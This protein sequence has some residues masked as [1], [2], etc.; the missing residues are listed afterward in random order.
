MNSKGL[1][2][3]AFSFSLLAILGAT[4]AARAQESPQAPPA[5]E[6]AGAAGDSAGSS[7]APSGGLNL[8][9]KLDDLVKQD[10]LVPGLS[11]PVSTVERQT[12]TIG[13]SPTA[14]FVIT[15]E[16]IKRSGVRSIPE[17]LRMAPGIDVARVNSQTWA[18]SARGFNNTFANKLLVQI[19]G[20]VVYN[21]TFG[22]VYWNQQ[23]V[24][25][26]DVE[27]IE[28]IRGP[29]TTM[30]G[31]NAMNGVINVIT[32]KSSDTQGALIQSGGG[33]QE[34]DFNTVRYG[35]KVGEDLT[36]RAYGQ[37]FNRNRGWSDDGIDDTWL[38]QQ[39]GFRL[40]YTPTK[41][42]T[43]TLQGDL[44]DGSGGARY[45]LASPAPPFGGEINPVNQFPAGN[46]LLRYG[47]VIDEDTSWQVQTYYDHYQQLTPQILDETRD[48]WDIDLQY[49][50]RPAPNHQFI[51]GCNYRRSQD[52]FKNS[53]AVG[54]EPTRY[55]T[56]WSGVFAQDTMT[57]E[58]DRWYFTIGTRLEQNTFGGFQVEPTARLLFL[59]SDRQ[60]AWM[61]VSRAIRNPTRSDV[62]VN[63]KQHAGPPNVPVFLNILGNP[64]IQPENM[65]AYELG[66]RAAPTDDFTW[67]IAGYINDYH[68]IMGLGTIGGPVVVPP[69]YVFFPST[70]ENNARA[71]SYGCEVTGT[72]QLNPDWRLFASYS[73]FEVQS[74]GT[75]DSTAG[76]IEGSSPSNQVYLRSSWDLSEDVQ[77]DLI[78][79]YVDALTALDVPKYIEMDAR[80]GWQATKR[81]EF[82]FVG[83]NLLNN[84]HLE[85]SDIATGRI[86]TQ[87]RRGWYAMV[88][89]AY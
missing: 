28:V 72:Y 40:D 13:R 38:A 82:S 53:F 70:L 50:F 77:F 22:G 33:D 15:P 27:R 85:F 1:S 10:V 69:G 61:A 80:I 41:E 25:L 59:P 3:L 21:G 88:S 43:F 49:Q 48:T 32:K 47:R 19:D 26:P 36:W 87:V 5:G 35:G 57:L 9:M 29:G 86:P 44:F 31:S 8:D 14:V 7:G 39:G 62:N 56:E 71:L 24:V 73:L 74:Q 79:R 63:F 30:W 52:A 89:W 45:N 4:V 46:L 16:M 68:K 55:V 66:Y 2:T 58:E 20:R 84:H 34:R 81:M 37:E 18:I 75:N 60:S 12:S 65:L 23:S 17:A 11:T 78:G 83:Q 67:D 76:P 51:T 6:P 54:F 64:G 42:D